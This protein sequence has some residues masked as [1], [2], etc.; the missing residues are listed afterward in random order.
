M[1]TTYVS[2]EILRLESLDNCRSRLRG[3]RLQ[4]AWK[5]HARC[6]TRR[7]E[8]AFVQCRA[9]APWPSA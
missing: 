4:R 2:V 1:L 5:R 6:C 3:D 9:S 7:P 8:A